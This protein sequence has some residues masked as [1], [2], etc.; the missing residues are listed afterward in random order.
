MAAEKPAVSRPTGK[1]AAGK[2]I[3]AAILKARL[4]S[5]RV[6]VVGERSETRT[7]WANPDGTLTVDQA[8]GPVRFR[9]KGGSWSKVD[10]GLVKKADGRIGSKAHPLGLTLAGATPRRNDAAAA[11][12][13]GAAS[14]VAASVP[15]VSLTKGKGQQ[16]TLGWRG[17]L[18]APDIEGTR[19]TYRGALPHADLV[20]DATRT[21]FEQFLRLRS[22]EAVG[23]AGTLRMT[24][25]AKGLKA[26]A[27]NG[28]VT[29]TDA[30]TGKTAGTMP[31]PVMWDNRRDKHTGTHTHR[32]PVA[33][34]VDQHGDQIDLTLRPAK[35]FLADP[36]TRFPVTVD[37]SVNLPV[38]FTTF[39]QEG[40]TTDLSTA[41][42]LRIGGTP[43]NVARS[44]LRFD[45]QPVKNQQITAA[46]LK[47][48]NSN[49]GVGFCIARSWEVWDTNN[50]GTAT[51]WTS[52]PSWNRKWATSTQTKG[53]GCDPGWV[54]ANVKTLVQAWSTNP[55]AE[56]ILGVRATNENDV[57]AFKQFHSRNAAAN[58]P[59]LSVTYNTQPGTASAVAF[60]P[61]AHNPFNQ[62]TYATS[63]TP[64]FTAK[65]TDPEGAAVKAQFEVVGEP[66]ADGSVYTWTGTSAAVASGSTAKLTLPTANKLRAGSHRVRARA[67]DGLVY[68]PWS[69]YSTF[70]VNVVRPNA[71]S[72]S[73]NGITRDQWNNIAPGE[74]DCTFTTTS[75]DGRGFLWG[76]ND[77]ATKQAVNDPAGT[78]GRPQTVKVNLTR[79][80]HT[81]Y[82]RTVDSGGLLSGVVAVQ[83]GVGTEPAGLTAPDVPGA[84]QEGGL[85][86]AA[87]LL[88]GVVTTRSQMS[89]NGEFALFDAAGAALPGVVLPPMGAGSGSRVATMVPEGALTPGTSYQWAMRACSDTAC[90]PWSTKKTFTAKTP[91][92]A[93]APQTSSVTLSGTALQDA[94]APVGAQDCGGTP[95]A[96]VQDDQL[97][98]GTPDGISWRTWFKADLTAVPA[99]ARITGARLKLHRVDCVD[100]EV[101]E[102][103]G[104]TVRELADAWTPQQSGQDLAAASS[105]ATHESED[106]TTVPVG[107]LDLGPLVDSWRSDD[108][109]HG[110]SL[111]LGD[112]KT[113]A[114][115]MVYHSSRADDPA[116]RPQLIIDYIAATAPT[117]P[118]DVRTV[119]A[120]G[121]LLAV[122]N[123]PSDTGSS[124]GAPTYTVVAHRGGAEVFRTTTTSDRVSVPGL[125]NGQDHTVTVTAATSHGTSPAVTTA[126]VKPQAVT[127]R[128]GHLQ[129]VRDY[130]AARSGLLKGTYTTLDQAVASS[131]HGVK[132]RALLAEQAP[133]LNRRRQAVVGHGLHYSSI[134]TTFDNLLAGPG[135]N[136]TVVVRGGVKEQLNLTHTDGTHEPEEGEE[137]G[138]FVFDQ[139]VLRM[140][141]DD[142][143]VET[144]LP[145]DG[146][147]ERAAHTAEPD[148]RDLADVTPVTEEAPLVE[149]NADGM[150]PRTGPAPGGP[151]PRRAPDHSG[152][153]RWALGNMK[154]KSE[155]EY[156]QDCTNFVSKA[157]N[158]GG[159]MKQIRGGRENVARWFRNNVGF[160]RRDSVTW[161]VT[162]KLRTHLKQHRKGKE[163]S[164][165]DV[166]PGDIAFA[167]YNTPRRWNHAGVISKI[168]GWTIHIAQH[169]G[170]NRTTVQ[171]WTRNPDI[172]QVS[173]IRP[174]RR[175]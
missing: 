59:V 114:P 12:R 51:R 159:K 174:G 133:E 40:H 122:W 80:W 29:F 173:F 60:T 54:S 64:T 62:R 2:G 81:L 157:L 69:A 72:V 165:L 127:D 118:R 52:Q 46:T 175:S 34:T 116:K 31:A 71:P 151:S 41:Q 94:T 16:V 96:A 171:N 78:H 112:E 167:W 143:A 144:T 156:K 23:R 37:P 138:H 66:A 47:L 7:L 5:K 135:P 53:G 117:A 55:H 106:E 134:T 139:G 107:S 13:L 20:V 132:F 32:A 136:G 61:S 145:E 26:R 92:S 24:L 39:V 103:P 102:E 68:G 101:C 130:F 18:P 97:Q 150:F 162:A 86:T 108:D 44:F 63:V 38:T 160:Q 8:A 76:L 10:I 104:A 99:G 100:G 146:A 67:Y 83:F 43:G 50:V 172:G 140:E 27:S 14:S 33:L 58:I 49:S 161:T 1:P 153:A 147:A 11:R 89:L 42:H 154:P 93:P 73:C 105:E 141:A 158:R 111:Q 28:G 75:T 113:A 124:D 142:T 126:A 79:G 84:L 131:P 35:A 115:G 6:E 148:A 149:M 119:T 48:W 87:P 123:A 57:L 129:A 3:T 88:S 22:R 65:V 15:L 128:D 56:N 164:L 19:A 170:R 152:T 4:Q 168:D 109:N 121:G 110:I 98:V 90:S 137:T 45:T 163:I 125:V 9:N 82:V 21:G 70:G 166:R 155:W 95:C 36:A 120:D 30:K 91:H 17:A 25:T 85:E 77:P 74:V 169:G